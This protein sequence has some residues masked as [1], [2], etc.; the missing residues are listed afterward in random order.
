MVALVV[1]LAHD[2]KEERVRVV[3]EGLVVQ[4]ELGEKAEVLGV[5]LVLASVNFEKR[6]RSFSKKSFQWA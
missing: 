2:V 4:E 5:H 1:A 3:I 6:Q